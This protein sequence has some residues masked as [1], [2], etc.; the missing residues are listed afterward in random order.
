MKNALFQ[1][2]EAEDEWRST[3][4]QFEEKWQ[5]P[6]CLGAADGKH[7]RITTP[8]GSGSLFW[9]YKH[10]HSVVLMACANANY[11]FIWCEVGTNGRIS[12]GGAIKNTEF[13][14][15]L[16]N[17]LLKIPPTERCNETSTELPYV[18]G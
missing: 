7:V 13:F 8:P 18:C 15:K 3:A 11:E 5:F 9:N 10:F 2:P 4:R 14:L 6:H 16:N 1:M 12:D 17:G